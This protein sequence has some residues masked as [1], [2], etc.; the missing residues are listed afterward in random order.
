MEQIDR[1]EWVFWTPFESAQ[2]RI[3]TNR[4]RSAKRMLYPAEILLLTAIA[5][6]KKSTEENFLVS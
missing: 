5:V 2:R 6:E 3:P 1:G 4:R